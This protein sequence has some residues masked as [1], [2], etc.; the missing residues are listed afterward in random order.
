MTT[1]DEARAPIITDIIEYVAFRGE[2][3]TLVWKGSDAYVAV[4]PI[5]ER[6]GIDPRSQRRKVMAPDSGW[7]WG[8]MTSPSAGGAQES[9]ALHVIELPLWLASISPAKVKPELREA[10]IAYRREC[11]LVLFEHVKSRLLGERD[12]MAA[13]LLRMQTEAVARKPLRVKVRDFLAAGHDFDWIW[14]AVNRPRHVVEETI[15]DLERLG[16]IDRRPAGFPAVMALPAPQL[17]LFTGA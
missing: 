2:R 8:Y 15:L 4:R 7:R 9:I 16:I 11:A 6:L 1:N 13:C 12:A 10:L 5:C 14:R 3:L 17:D